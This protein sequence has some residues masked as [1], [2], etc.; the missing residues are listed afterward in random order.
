MD[1]S[2]NFEHLE[3]R[4]QLDAT[5]HAKT[6]AVDVVG[7]GG[8]DT[9]VVQETVNSDTGVFHIE[10]FVNSSEQV[11]D[12]S[13]VKSINISSGSGPDNINEQTVA[14]PTTLD[15]GKGDDTLVGGIANDKLIGG[16]G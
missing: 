10:V 16:G 1:L 15:G 5:F 6:G 2:M 8:A 14:I 4:L 9:I 11:F 13:K 3:S 7:T 12:A